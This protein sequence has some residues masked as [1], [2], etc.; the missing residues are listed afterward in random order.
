MKIP[1]GRRQTSWLF[2]QRGRGVELGATENKCSEWQGGGLEPGTTTIQI[3]RPNDSATPRPNLT[4]PKQEGR[5]TG[6]T[7]R[8]L[9]LISFMIG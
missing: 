7:K 9:V 1:T 8:R 6:M 4:A 5:N 3:Q 2:K